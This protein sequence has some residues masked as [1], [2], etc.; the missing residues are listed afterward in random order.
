MLAQFICCGI[1]VNMEARRTSV[2]ERCSPILQ[3]TCC[4]VTHC[5]VKTPAVGFLDSFCFG[6][7]LDYAQVARDQEKR[8]LEHVVWLLYCCVWGCG[9]GH[10]T[11]LCYYD[12]K[13]CCAALTAS[14]T[15]WSTEGGS[16]CTYSAKLGCCL[17]HMQW[18][19]TMPNKISCCGCLGA[20]AEASSR[21]CR[22]ER[23]R[24]KREA[25]ETVPSAVIVGAESTV[26][27]DC[28][29]VDGSSI[30][31]TTLG[32]GSCEGAGV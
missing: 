7:P 8:F 26:R 18:L 14:T 22:E 16:L 24:H 32:E 15:P 23:Q 27:R 21:S 4:C 19:P 12:A 25:E 9:V 29:A 30:G 13:V 5:S 31:V 6:D 28:S 3:K 17:A 1:R 11:P 10:S 20:S 2:G